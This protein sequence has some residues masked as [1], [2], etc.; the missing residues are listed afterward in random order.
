MPNRR[1]A[2]IAAASLLAIPV[3]LLVVWRMGQDGVLRGVHIADT[4]VSGLSRSA[5]DDA[6]AEA[7]QEV[8]DHQV[9]VTGERDEVATT[10]GD[11]GVQIDRG[12]SVDAAWRRGRQGNPFAAFW[13]H[14]RARTGASITVEHEQTVDEQVVESWAADVAEE[15]STQRRDATVRFHD[16]EDPPGQGNRSRAQPVEAIAGRTVDADELADMVLDALDD[17]GPVQLQAPAARD[18]APAV[19]DADVEAVLP[20]ARQAV[21]GAITLSHPHPR[22]E[23]L[24]LTPRDLAAVLRINA[25]EDADEGQRLSLALPADALRDHLGEDR[26]ESLNVSP[27]DAEFVV[28][29]DDVSVRGGRPGYRFDAGEVAAAVL[30]LAVTEERVADL[31]GERP[32]PDFTRGDA[33]DLEIRTRVSEFTT[34]HACCE[35]RVE[36]IQL[37][38]DV[39][40]GVIVRPGE[41][42]SINDHVGPRTREKGFVADGVI[43]DGEFEDQVGGGVSQ[44]ATTFFN[45]AFFAG[46]QI[47]Q[48][49][50][51]SYY[52]ERY[53][54]GHEATLAYGVL[55]VAI[56]NDSPHGIL[57]T[58]SYTDTSITV[59]FYSSQWAE[60]DVEVGPRRNVVEGDVRDGFDVNFTRT[61]TYP[62]GEQE[63]ERYSHTY[64]PENEDDED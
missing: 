6:V 61:I 27:R 16:D 10:R 60:V 14:L 25:D 19:T 28:D 12:A 44:F 50:P 13:D 42:F 32:R 40:D 5:L 11:V 49:Q 8:L 62:D 15:L 21:S 41:S 39:V 55:D 56:T 30:D 54:V 3:L 63:V 9:V 59:S 53:P 35:P 47:D 20:D 37:M 36:N 45:A 26:I 7:A 48:F 23:D 57:I 34:E 24:E 52:I 46:I 29:G 58:T 18:D 51:H 2:L 64:E 43:V 31:P 33:R 1:I 17:D 4:D 38:A 22:G